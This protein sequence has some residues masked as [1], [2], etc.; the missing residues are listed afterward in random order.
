MN[1]DKLVTQLT[2]D[3]G[4]RLRP[5]LDTVG[6]RTIGIGRN[7]DDVG[8]SQ[9]EAA[10]MLKNDIARVESQL[11]KALSWW[12]TMSDD[13]QQVLAN[14]CFNMGITTLLTFKNTLAAMQSGRYSDAANG[15]LSS[16]WARQV[17]AR[18]VRLSD[19]M[20]GK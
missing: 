20:R 4:L 10:Y 11:D 17:G 15:M 5:Y 18:A 19:V 16:V 14:M 7:L 1:I 12:R 2:I 6:K 3:E 13:R 8:I 9:D